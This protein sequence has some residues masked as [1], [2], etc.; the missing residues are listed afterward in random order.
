MAILTFCVYITEGLDDFPYHCEQKPVVTANYFSLFAQLDLLTG[1]RRQFRNCTESC[2]KKN[3]NW[4]HTI[5][6]SLFPLSK[7][8]LYIAACCLGN[9]VLADMFTQI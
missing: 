9:H 2:C 5:D 7:Q 4:L 3:M 6:F 8:S 1:V